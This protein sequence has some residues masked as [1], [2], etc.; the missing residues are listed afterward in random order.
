MHHTVRVHTR[1]RSCGR[2]ELD[3]YDDNVVELHFP[4]S[5]K[6]MK[7]DDLIK[8]SWNLRVHVG[9]AMVLRRFVGHYQSRQCTSV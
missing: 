9:T 2:K 7:F 1:C 4:E 5:C 8:F 3:T 6:S